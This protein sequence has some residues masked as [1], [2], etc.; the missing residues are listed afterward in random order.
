M[1]K[2]SKDAASA[3]MSFKEFSRNNTTV[4]L[5][6]RGDMSM[7][8]FG[9]EIAV[10][11]KS[12]E[13]FVTLCGWDSRTTKVRLCH[14]PGVSVYHQKGIRHINGTPWN[15]KWCRIIFNNAFSTVLV[16]TEPY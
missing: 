2:I 9:N 1:S 3:L 12:G 16:D 15:G 10:Y 8:L 5:N 7:R 14:I 4:R 13:L 11:K 6:I